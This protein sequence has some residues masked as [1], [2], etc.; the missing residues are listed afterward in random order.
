MMV[1]RWREF[2]GESAKNVS[3]DELVESVYYLDRYKAPA[4]L[5]DIEIDI[6]DRNVTWRHLS[7][8]S[9]I[10]RRANLVEWGLHKRKGGP[11]STAYYDNGIPRLKVYQSDSGDTKE[12]KYYET[13]KIKSETWYNRRAE[14]H[15]DGGPAVIRYDNEGNIIESINYYLGKEFSAK[16]EP[17]EYIKKIR[18]VMSFISY[19]KLVNII[20]YLNDNK[21]MDVE[22]IKIDNSPI[23]YEFSKGGNKVTI[24]KSGSELWHHKNVLHRIGEPAMMTYMPDKIIEGWYFNGMLHREGEEPAETIYDMYVNPIKETW[25]KHGVVVR[26]KHY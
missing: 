16:M 24:S 5:R 26:E 20:H 19:E 12:I 21:S 9:Y 3:D 14:I 11:N 8:G 18:T 17:D 13:G 6:F 7:S 15:R 23:L 1:R 22:G 2:F 4:L 25:V 10:S